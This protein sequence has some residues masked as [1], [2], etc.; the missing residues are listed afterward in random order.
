[1]P[2]TKLPV[3]G[4]FHA[5]VMRGSVRAIFNAEKDKLRYTRCPAHAL[6]ETRYAKPATK[7][8]PGIFMDFSFYKVLV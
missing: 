1:V 8:S 4:W 3:P 5:A 7:N 6:R 2:L